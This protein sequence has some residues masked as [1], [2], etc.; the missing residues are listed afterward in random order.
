M[1]IDI[2]VSVGRKYTVRSKSERFCT[3]AELFRTASFEFYF[4]VEKTG[5]EGQNLR[6]KVMNI[7]TNILLISLTI[8]AFDGDCIEEGSDVVSYKSDMYW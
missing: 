2:H 7:S 3:Q 1:R 5:H 4:A 8:I 6:Q